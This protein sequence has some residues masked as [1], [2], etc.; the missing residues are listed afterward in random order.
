MKILSKM[1]TF[2]CV[3]LTGA[4]LFLLTDQNEVY[5]QQSRDF[6]YSDT[7]F[8]K[9]S[10]DELIEIRKHYDNKVGNY[11]EREE[12]SR[13]KGMDWS[14]SFLNEKTEQVKDRDKVYIR[15]AEYYIEEAYQDYNEKVDAHDQKYKEYEKQLA[16]YDAGELE[17]EPEPP[18]FPVYDFTAAI[19]IYDRILNEYPSS[20]YADDAMYSKA[21]LLERMGEGKESRR[22]YQE[23]INKYPESRF[24]AESYMRLAEYFFAPRED[25]TEEGQIIVELKKA[26]QLYKNVL[27]YKDSKRY[28][29]ALYKL[30]WSYYKLAVKDPKY[31][32]DAIAY[33]MAVAD[34]IKRAR[35][36]DP[37]GKIS[38][39]LVRDEAIQYIGISF[40]D[41]A[42]ARNGVDKAAYLL[43][44]IGDRQYGP[45]IF[46]AMGQTYQSIDE[47]SK[48]IYAYR[49][50]LDR[51]QS[52]NEAPVIQKN[53]VDALY[54]LGRDQEAYLA[55]RNL[56]QDYA[57]GSDWYARMDTSSLRERVSYLDK[58][59]DLSE[60]ALRTNILL[61]L[62]KAEELQ[63]EGQPSTEE[64]ETFADHSRLYLELFPSDSNAYDINWSY[65]FMLDSRLGR[66]EE[67][68]EEYIRVSNDYLETEHQH[69]AA[70]NAVA[71]AD[72][73]VDM[74]FGSEQDSV[75]V[76]IANFAQLNPETL[77]PEESRL[78]EAYDNYIRLF[79]DGQYTPNFLAAAGGIYYNHKKFAEAKVYF[80][81]LVKRFPGAEEKS[82]ALRSIMDS[83]FALG[84]FKDSEVIAKRILNEASISE[85]QKEFAQ[86]RLGQAIFKNAE[87]MEEQ[88]DFFAA[89]NEYKRVFVESPDDPR[90]AEA[91]LYNSGLNFE[92]VKDWVRAIE[93]YDTLATIYP[94]SKY[95]LPAMEKMAKAHTELEDFTGAA[96]IY[97]RIYTEFNNTENAEPALY[98]A[99]YYYKKGEDWRNA[100]RVN[101][102]YIE[103]Y[104]DQ[105]YSVDLF[106]SN[107]Q[108]YLN[109]NE[110]DQA[111][112]IYA[113]FA[114]QYP[115]DPRTVTAFYERGKYYQENDMPDRAKSEFNKAITR[116][117]TFRQEGKDPNAFI[118]G[119]ASKELA[120]ILYEEFATIKLQPPQNNIDAQMTRMR[121]LLN[122][123]K[124]AYSK[125]LGFG[126]PS[127]FEATYNIARSYEK[128]AE[129][130][131]NQE[132]DESLDSDKKFVKKQEINQQAANLYERA[133]EE[134]KTVVE[135]LPD[136]ADRLGVDMQPKLPEPTAAIDT[137]QQQEESISRASM[138]DSTR[139]LAVKYNEKAKDKISE[140]MYNE[141]NLMSKNVYQAVQI[142]APH[143]DPV[144]NIVYVRTVL[145]KVASPAIEKTIVA[146]V[147]N[148][149]QSEE[150]GL[151]NKYVEESKRQILLTSNILAEE[152]EQ[153][154]YKALQQHA[155][156]RQE[157][158]NLVDKEYG[159]VNEDG[160]DYFALDNIANQMVDY[161]RLLSR[162]IINSYAKTL[163]VAQE[164]GIKNDLISR[165]QDHMLRYAIE[166]TDTMQ[167]LALSAQE[168]AEE[169]KTKFD[170]TQNYNFDD[171]SVFFENYYFNLTDF[172][173]EILDVAFSAREQFDIKGIWANKLLYK[174]I[175][176]DPVTYSASI[177]KENVT[178]KSDESWVYSKTYDPQVWT[179]LDYDDSDWNNAAIVKKVNTNDPFT[180]LDLAEQPH[181][182]WFR[183]PS[184]T[185]SVEDTLFTTDSLNADTALVRG[186][187]IAQD[188]LMMPDTATVA[189]AAEPA[190]SDTI[191]FFR[192]TFTLDGTPV[193]GKIYITADDDY[194]VY[195]NGEYLIDDPDNQFS[196]LDTLDYYT[197]EIAVNTGQNILAVDVEDKDLTGMGLK[198]YGSVEILP[199]DIT[200]AAE[201][202]AKV[203]RVVVDPER[204]ERI[205][206]LNKNRISTVE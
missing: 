195:L 136:I 92:K 67:A 18:Q 118:A 155:K 112:Q 203:Q 172:S 9:M 95:A 50:L 45:E 20:E 33:F 46:E 85:S 126:S 1:I 83:Y 99:S 162:D 17:E 149:Q 11:R 15:L 35:E 84:K 140:M 181:S 12:K 134:Y 13:I 73:L 78:I 198:V 150:L 135:K 177:E 51:Y 37:R 109:L 80:Q 125:V 131:A 161:T 22:I 192:K 103:Q 128:F 71:V 194:R 122:E 196:V 58:A 179:G 42:F 139:L 171:A 185:L 59:Y 174:L 130:Y 79:P 90:L 68:F 190:E 39:Q 143:Q 69:D 148:L 55:R 57:P 144:K 184:D 110:I 160:Y 36:L 159:A 32:K 205:N 21:W 199:A 145:N 61:D 16:R 105:S 101:N 49:T 29:E 28:D 47:Q 53:I 201:E 197:F 204:L 88:G 167:T 114:N 119:K 106:F 86:K 31:Y 91:A 48:A 27:K 193:S 107:A 63:A 165:T 5:A 157:I 81:T 40:I 200:S 108:L 66:F 147:Q 76:N 30:G 186:T 120:D 168:K 23:I 178:I 173:R 133:A 156:T 158:L 74:K 14:E 175:K 56:Y 116:S 8:K 77:T 152:I 41:T 138:V 188:S 111:N 100:I 43:D 96:S 82:L 166:I 94:D 38:N 6:G 24:A 70:V 26:I 98:N 3:L 189:T 170:E 132:L 34:D 206:I 87:Y 93:T 60:A 191:G 164:Y 62:E 64:Y 115:D 142:E 52:Y 141:A 151:S 4:N 117:E 137:L 163:N 176:L 129:I 123:L 169:F 183:Q 104:P 187:E 182:I 75:E 44:R 2:V 124:Q 113:E 97:E 102:E 202:K 10:I 54:S 19:D 127:S 146:H 72:T 65:A 7:L 153:L 180:N 25:K 154:A 121:N 89:A